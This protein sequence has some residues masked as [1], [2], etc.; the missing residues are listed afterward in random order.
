MC[1]LVFGGVQNS[2]VVFAVINLPQIDV[3]F[4][5]LLDLIPGTNLTLYVHVAHAL[6]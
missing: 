1:L 5:V 3:Y 6:G 4:M 2:L